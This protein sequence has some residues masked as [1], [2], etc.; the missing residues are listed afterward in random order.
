MKILF[1]QYLSRRALKLVWHIKVDMLTN[2]SKHV[3]LDASELNSKRINRITQISH[4]L[5]PLLA[6]DLSRSLY[7][8]T[9]PLVVL[10]QSDSFLVG[11]PQAQD[12]T[13]F[14]FEKLLLLA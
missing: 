3:L 8:V 1:S 4:K 9:C 5:S 10:L 14:L 12:L 7:L 2:L 6:I 11:H 13:I